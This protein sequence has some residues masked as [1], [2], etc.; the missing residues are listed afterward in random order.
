[1]FGIQNS[2]LKTPCMKLSW[3]TKSKTD[4]MY[5]KLFYIFL[6][7]IYIVNNG[8]IWNKKKIEQEL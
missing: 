3:C 4:K 6:F 8:N 1:M 7:I 2:A 5:S